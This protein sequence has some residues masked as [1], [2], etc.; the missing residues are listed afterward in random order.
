MKVSG[1]SPALKKWSPFIVLFVIL[2]LIL[3]RSPKFGYEYRKGSEWKYE[4]L[5][6]QFDFPIL[7][8]DEQIRE[9]RSRSVSSV[10]PYYKY[11]DDVVN[12][13]LRAA[14]AL[15]LGRDAALKPAIVSI[16]RDIYTQGVVSDEGVKVD[17][18]ATDL[19]EEILYVQKDKR[20]VKMP[21]TEVYKQSDAKS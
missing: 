9:E 14:E 7:K 20:A 10:I 1:I 15:S 8:T 21:V 11:Y 17:R 12:K 19:S 16:I 2:V 5:Y 3:P 18:N 13:N 6:A 4:T